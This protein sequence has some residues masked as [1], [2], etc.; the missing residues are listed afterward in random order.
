MKNY[1]L[2]ILVCLSYFCVVS[3]DSMA[4]KQS[5][6]N[7]E[8]SSG[9]DEELAA[10]YGADDY[11]MKLYVMAFLKKGP[12]RTEDDALAK[13][14]QSQHME[15]IGKLAEEGKLVL[16]GPFGGDGDLRGIYIF[17]T[18]SVDEAKAWTETDPAIIAGSLEME[19]I[20]WYGSA[21]VMGINEVH[22]KIAKINI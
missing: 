9:F 1:W 13:K 18:D 3:C 21:A 20:Q 11:G 14:L 22:E 17:N 8:E 19:L 7:I 6:E 2:F 10:K 12:N 16:A 4:E 15:N 5:E